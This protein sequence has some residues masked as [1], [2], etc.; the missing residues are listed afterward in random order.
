MKKTISHL[1]CLSLTALLF[2]TACN[3]NKPNG[4]DV[5]SANI[6]DTTQTLTQDTTQ[7]DSTVA[8]IDTTVAHPKDTT[9]VTPPK[10]EKPATVKE[11]PK[12]NPKPQTT[13][14]PKPKPKTDPPKVGASAPAP[15]Q[16]VLPKVVFNKWRLD[17]DTPERADGGRTY[18]PDGTRE[19]K[20]ARM[21]SVIDIRENGTINIKEPG[22][23]DAGVGLTG[24]WTSPS[25]KEIIVTLT[26]GSK[27]KY[28]I[29]SSS[30]DELIIKQIGL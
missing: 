1:T 6:T 15:T 23:V 19:I 14:T 3:G 18:R 21:W 8:A 22:P 24:K 7:T 16:T 10:Q 20:G 27:R 26:D 9:T 29:L 2:V 5:S 28:T 30:K 25:K 4:A 13:P 11:T 17:T 12:P